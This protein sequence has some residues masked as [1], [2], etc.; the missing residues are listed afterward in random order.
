MPG[1]LGGV[2]QA[3]AWAGP[4]APVACHTHRP[5]IR[6][7]HHL[8]HPLAGRA[9]NHNNLYYSWGPNNKVMRTPEIKLAQPRARADLVRLDV[10][11]K[12]GHVAAS[13]MAG[14]L[15]GNGP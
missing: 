11:G 13:V 14:R 1:C 5:R 2:I 10:G 8:T 7:H 9:C 4:V 12:L 6:Y 15:G 3:W